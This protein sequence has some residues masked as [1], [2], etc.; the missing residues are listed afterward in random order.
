MKKPFKSLNEKY[1]KFAVVAFI[2]FASGVLG[3]QL[4]V[5]P[6]YA[7]A[8]FPA[9]G[10]GLAAVL[11]GGNA[12]LISVWLGSF[13]I[14]NWLSLQHASPSIS[15]FMIAAL[16]ASGSALQAWAGASVIRKLLGERWRQLDHEADIL[17][18]LGVN[19][20]VICMISATIGTLTLWAFGAVALDQTV[21]N[22]WNWWVGDTIGVLLITPLLLA[23]FLR[24]DALWKM[25]ARWVVIPTLV[26]ALAIVTVFFYTSQ[27]ETA[28][29]KASIAEQGEFISHRITNEVTSYSEVVTALKSF[30]AVSPM[31]GVD[32]FEA[33]ASGNFVNHPYLHALSWNPYLPQAERSRFEYETASVLSMPDYRVM[34]RDASGKL[35][36]ALQRDSYVPVKYIYPF[37]NNK[38]AFGFD[39]ASNNVRKTAIDTA[40]ANK[41]ITLTAPIKLV[42]ESG[43][44]IG[45]LLLDPIFKKGDAPSGEN[46]LDG[47][48][49]AVFRV[50]ELFRA[51]LPSVLPEGLNISLR[52]TRVDADQQVLFQMEQ[53]DSSFLKDFGWSRK[54]Q[55]GGREWQLMVIPTEKYI[56]THRTL[57]PWLILLVGLTLTSFLQAILLLFTG[58]SSAIQRLVDA[59]TAELA[60]E[61][62]ERK[63]AEEELR[64]AHTIYQVSSEGMMVCDANNIILAVNPALTTLT[65]YSAE[66]IIGQDP[67]VLSSGR[68]GDE[69]Y[70]EMWHVINTSGQ[71]QGEIWNRKKNGEHFAEWLTINTL[72]S[73][74]GAV[75]RR[76]ALFSDITAKKNADA[77]ILKQA[78]YDLLTGLPNRRL[79]TDRLER[80]VIQAQ[81]NSTR[82]ALFFIDL[83]YFKEINDTLGHHVGDDLL[84]KA[85]ER[86][87]Q[88]VRESDTVARLG[89]DEFTVILSQLHDI[90]NAGKIAQNIIDTLV[91]PFQLGDE[92]V[93]IS[94]SVGVTF[95]PEDA[96]T[97]SGLLQNADQAMYAAKH[98]G[99]NCFS[100]FTPSMQTAAINKMRL[101]RDLR[102]A[103]SEKQLEV[104]YQPIVELSTG[105]IHK[106]EALMRWRHPEHGYISPATFIPIA[107]ETGVI[108]EIGEWIFQQ[109]VY[110]VVRLREIGHRD[111]QISVNK[112]PVQFK[113]RDGT[114]DHWEDYL[115]SHNVS[116]SAIVVEITEGLLLHAE[117]STK[118]QLLHMRD[119][120]TQVAIDDFG[121]GYSALSY[122]QKFDIDYLKIDQSFTRNLVVGDDSVALCEAIVMMAHKLGLKVIAEGIETEQQRE[123]LQV[124]GCDYGQ[125]YLFSRPLPV[126]AF[127]GL[128]IKS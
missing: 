22:W 11:L 60:S 70:Q 61:L 127:E 98:Q 105:H 118:D 125:G 28:K 91:Q 124:M 122:L 66:E 39:I 82:F 86:I 123:I 88:C 108:H 6:G 5:P 55:V 7:T 100:F 54:L 107:E 45:L 27:A 51:V 47:F 20:A 95:Y 62:N 112:S 59:K 79:F 94:G 101:A 97:T 16:I 92:Q 3:L 30:I 8:I 53:P 23:F 119:M 9:A 50:E 58:R 42:Q 64:L 57:V 15:G 13:V 111:F 75:Y 56:E 12:Y 72:Y 81:R 48:A 120:G 34:E 109:A 126:E 116:G 19:G 46:S 99:R 78:N 24:K 32:Q 4:A 35:V 67:R 36:P 89:G 80:E 41:G 102:D 38:A 17:K 40:I 85:S 106:A 31:L 84:I 71:W 74:D 2:Y 87:E 26:A 90:S 110:E 18:F 93:Y 37:N 83:D 14:N 44:S 115:S 25:R 76:I 77:L 114:H 1:I 21:F 69:F 49:V 29:L 73:D 117:Q 121:T 113:M 103:L 68:E 33:F 63:K 96:D 43:S 104:H 65:G 10:V 128:L 52:D